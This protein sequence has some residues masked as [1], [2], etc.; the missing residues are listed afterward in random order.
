MEPLGSVQKM[1]MGGNQKVLGATY[2]GLVC[3]LHY[4]TTGCE[5]RRDFH[6]DSHCK[7]NAQVSG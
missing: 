6:C 4:T 1:L 5:D 7:K 3:G 2:A